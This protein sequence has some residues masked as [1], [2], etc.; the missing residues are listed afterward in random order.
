M[1]IQGNTLTWTPYTSSR[2]GNALSPYW[3][4]RAMATLGGLDFDSQPGFGQYW[5]QYLP[6]KVPR[7]T[8][9]QP[10]KFDDACRRCQKHDWEF[11]HKCVGAWTEI[12]PVI[13]QETQA[14]FA[15][16]ANTTG[17]AIPAFQPSD[18]VIQVRCAKDTVLEH[19][20]YGPVG[21]SY[22]NNIPDS[23]TTV[24]VVADPGIQHTV[25]SKIYQA[26]VEYLQKRYPS[27]KVLFVGGSIEEDFARMLYAPTLFKDSQSSFG[28]WAGVANSGQVF[29]VPLLTTSVNNH[30]T[31]DMGPAWHWVDAPV[32]YPHVASQQGITIDQHDKI[33]VWLQTH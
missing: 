13:Q 4:A 17:F 31:P 1:G 8:C 24:Y 12:R 26:Q 10:D 16:W 23:T 22:Y 32:L 19:G 14:A 15:R 9:P 20:E 33:I 18:V 28:L 21:F 30:T 5:M 25:C 6:R 27:A 3:Q 11:A 29:S 2:W 7:T